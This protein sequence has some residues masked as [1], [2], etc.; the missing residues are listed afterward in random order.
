M[1]G[2]ITHWNI[3]G[4][5]CKSSP[6]YKDKVDLLTSI[7][8]KNSTFILNV[9]ETHISSKEDMPKFLEVYKHIYHVVKTLSPS[10]DR[11]SG[12]FICIRKTEEIIKMEVLENGRLLFI[13][14]LN[15]SSKEIINIFSI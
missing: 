9:Q 5:K 3:N 7:L 1:A 2:E 4:L 15:K 13:K 10:N 8:E 14:I 11:A 6:N 12:I